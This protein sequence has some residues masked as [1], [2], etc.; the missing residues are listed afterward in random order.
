MDSTL[1]SIVTIAAFWDK[2]YCGDNK[3]FGR[4][5]QRESTAFT[6]H[7]NQGLRP[8]CLSPFSLNKHNIKYLLACFDGWNLLFE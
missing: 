6:R 2:K 4:L 3:Q 5:A 1:D 8:Y 7:I